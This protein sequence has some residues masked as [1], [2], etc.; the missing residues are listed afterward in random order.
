MITILWKESKT[1]SKYRSAM[2][3]FM[4][5]FFVSNILIIIAS[6]LGILMFFR[7]TPYHL[8]KTFPCNEL[9]NIIDLDTFRN[10]FS[11]K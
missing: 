2:Y 11:K 7:L 9:D 1:L 4:I 3:W 10:E 6:M 8:L 5:L